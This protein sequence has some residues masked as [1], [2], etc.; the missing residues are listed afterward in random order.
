M[1]IKFYDPLNNPKITIK[2]HEA[3]KKSK[4]LLDEAKQKV[5]E[6]IKKSI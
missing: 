1:F 3:R 6:I 5:E 4:E 2:S